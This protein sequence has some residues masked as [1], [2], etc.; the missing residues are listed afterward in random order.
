MPSTHYDTL[1]VSPTANEDEIKKSYRK[2]SLKYHPD[3]NSSTEAAEKIREINDAYETLSDGSKRQ[4][5][6]HELRFGSMNSMGGDDPHDISQLFSMI[7][8]QG[9]P[10][11]QGFPGGQGFPGQSFA[12]KGFPGSQGFPGGQGFPGSQGF[13]GQVFPGHG[14]PGQ[15]FPGGI[16]GFHRMQTNGGPEIRIFH[17]NSGFPN[18]AGGPM[19][20]MQKPP[21]IVLNMVITLEQSYSGCT[22]PIEIERWVMIGDV[23]IQEQETLYVEIPPGIDDNEM[24]LVKEKGNASG[25]DCKGDVKITIEL[26]NNSSFKRSGLNL[27]LR[28]T[29]SLK[30]ALCGFEF[31]IHHINGKILH[32]NNKVNSNIIKPNFKKTVQGLGMKRDNSIGSLVIEFDVEFPESLSPEQIEGLAQILL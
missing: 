26:Q 21:P 8:G 1:G 11:S 6:D 20:R 27:L 23:K 4:Q 13:P 10:G 16:P 29:I 25:D 14:F 2:L 17:G 32:L 5:Y 22:L 9:F 31:D 15:G 19:F 18:M 12:S 30:E 7:F 24:I 3:R 28:K